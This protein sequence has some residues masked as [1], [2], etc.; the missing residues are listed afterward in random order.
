MP[1]TSNSTKITF[2]ERLKEDWIANG[3]DTFSLGFRAVAVHRI[4][5]VASSSQNRL[6]RLILWRVYWFWQRHCRN[7]GIEIPPGVRLGRRVGVFHQ[8]GI[9]FHPAAVIGDDCNIRHGVTLGASS[10]KRSR[11]APRLEAGVDIGVGAALLGD[12]VVGAR[13]RIGANV[14]LTESV[15]EDSVVVVQAPKI[16]RPRLVGEGYEEKAVN[17]ETS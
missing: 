14:V 8:G 4:G 5:E 13:S 11:K 16:L 3:R 6:V 10:T 1:E 15:P 2:R 17:N 7:R 9:V 12:I